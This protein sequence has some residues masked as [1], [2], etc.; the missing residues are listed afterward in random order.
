M[1]TDA[2]AAVPAEEQCYWH[3]H[4]PAQDGDYKV[5]GECGHVWRTEAEFVA[6]VERMLNDCAQFVAVQPEG[7]PGFGAP[8]VPADLTTIRYCPLCAHD[9]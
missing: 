8:V 1:S 3:G 7:H 2:I 9:F 5:C 6:D 4:E